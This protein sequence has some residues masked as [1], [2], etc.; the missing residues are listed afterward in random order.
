MKAKPKLFVVRNGSV[1]DSK[2]RLIRA[3]TAHQ[4]QK[5]LDDE[6]IRVVRD[7][8]SIE[9]ASADQALELG[10]AGFKVEEISEPA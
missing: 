1:D 9:V 5:F 10:A 6:A 2:P 4:V 3:Q 8:Q 7:G